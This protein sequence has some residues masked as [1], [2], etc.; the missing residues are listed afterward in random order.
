M[1]KTYDQLPRLEIPGIEWGEEGDLGAYIAQLSLD[2]GPI[3][4]FTPG[5]GPH[6]G[7]EVVY[8]VGPEAN[9]FVLQSHREHFSHDLGWT[10]M[11]GESLGHGLLNMDPPEHTRHRAMMNPAFTSAFM[12]TYLPL[13]HRVIDARTRDWAER[14]EVDMFEEAREITFDIAAAALV[15]FEAGDD[16]DWLRERFYILLHG[17]DERES[18]W[19]TYLAQLLR[20]RDELIGKLLQLIH[21]RRRAGDTGPATDVLG[22]MVRARDDEGRALTNEQLLAHVNILL[23]AGHETT[24][25]LGSW[26]LYFLAKYPE[27]ADRVLRELEA[28][29]NGIDEPISFDAIKG[30]PFLG[31]VIREA[32]RL[33]SPVMLLPRG[34]VQPFEFGGYAVPDGKPAMLAVAAGHRLPTVFANPGVFDPDRFDPPREEEKRTPY[35]LV[36]FGGGPRICIGVNFAQVEIKALVSHVLRRFQLETIPERPV[37]QTS[38]LVAFLPHGIPL[39]VTSKARGQA[40]TP[41]AAE[42]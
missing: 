18:D 1:I 12:A 3:F 28:A 37:T 10:P 17:F 36:T 7:E 38:G 40:T 2:H 29:T 33:R 14:G 15:G 6:S 5:M 39:H 19:E 34:I 42:G 25:T 16:V 35:S 30:T 13:M 8:M 23:V 32:G 4:V 20:V 31:N 26:V 41:N 21:E 27:L 24:T 22:M 9:R 11:I